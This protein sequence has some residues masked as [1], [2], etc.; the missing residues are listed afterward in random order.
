MRRAHGVALTTR[1]GRLAE[2][3]P[4]INR[5]AAG[6]TSLS[7]GQGCVGGILGV[8]PRVPQRASVDGGLPFFNGVEA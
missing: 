7:L 5:G 6:Q 8:A 2:K 3:P 1:E 4:G